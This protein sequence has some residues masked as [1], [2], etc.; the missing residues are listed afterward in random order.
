MSDIKNDTNSIRLFG[1]ALLAVLFATVTASAQDE[2]AR[3]G[4]YF[5]QDKRL[6][7]L[8]RPVV[9]GMDESVVAILPKRTDNQLALGTIVGAD[10]WILTS[11][12]ALGREKSPS[13]LFA[14]DSE[15]VAE[16]VKRY[17]DHDIAVL[18]VDAKGLAA[19]TIAKQPNYKLGQWL[20]SVGVNRDPLDVGVMSVLPRRLARGTAFLGVSVGSIEEDVVGVVINEV[21]EG[22]SAEK[23]GL[24]VD[25]VILSIGKIEMDSVQAFVEAIRAHDEGDVIRVVVRRGEKKIIKE[26]KL[27]RR[28]ST[29]NRGDRGGGRRGRN[30]RRQSRYSFRRTGYPLVLQHDAVIAPSDCGGPVVD[31]EGRLVALNISRSD[32]IETLALPASVLTKVVGDIAKLRK[33]PVKKKPSN[34]GL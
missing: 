9:K 20:I 15:R 26:I 23:F 22:S 18:K 3:L 12:S 24:R 16:I 13:C 28:R 4:D 2:L 31:I 14:D 32:R 30:F 21:T 33:V 7:T 17:D 6:K 8:F 29:E 5:R 34:S 11:A 27:G 1:F 25:D 19:L 10:G